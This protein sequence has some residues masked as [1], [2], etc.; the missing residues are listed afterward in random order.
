MQKQQKCPTEGSLSEHCRLVWVKKTAWVK[1]E[2]QQSTPSR[3]W[4][5]DHSCW[6]HN[7]LF[8]L[9]M[10]HLSQWTQ[11]NRYQTQTPN[12]LASTMIL[13]SPQIF[14]SQNDCHYKS[15]HCDVTREQ[16]ATFYYRQLELYSPFRLYRPPQSFIN[17]VRLFI[18]GGQGCTTMTTGASD[19]RPPIN[20]SD[21]CVWRERILQNE[22]LPLFV[23][24]TENAACI[25]TP[26]TKCSSRMLNCLWDL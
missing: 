12:C 24:N 22:R 21:T 3:W 17:I 14:V 2:T 6:D 11:T 19:C 20:T 15:P 18:Q 26:L 8:V 23:H 7:D 16:I 9:Q 13:Q 4:Q 5:W 25:K 1:A 10:Q